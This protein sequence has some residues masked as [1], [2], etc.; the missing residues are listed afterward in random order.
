MKWVNIASVKATVNF[1][2]V[3]KATVNFAE[4]SSY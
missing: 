1:A 4:V 2:E 3:S